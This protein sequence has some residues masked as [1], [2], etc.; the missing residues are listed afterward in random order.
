MRLAEFGRGT[1]GRRYTLPALLGRQPARAGNVTDLRAQVI[2]SAAAGLN[3]AAGINAD[4]TF[5]DTRCA[6]AAVRDRRAPVGGTAEV[7]SPQ[8]EREICERV[9]GDRRHGLKA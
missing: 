9:L 5:Q 4:L 1:A 3:A 6:V 7:F 2:S 8:S